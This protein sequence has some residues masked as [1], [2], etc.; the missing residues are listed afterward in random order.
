MKIDIISPSKTLFSGDAELVQL[1]GTL[2]SFEILNDHAPIVS[3]LK[4]GQVKVITDD[5]QT[6]F[7]DV[8]GGVTEVLQNKIIILVKT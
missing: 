2:G 1:P 8:K 4:E 6:L 3:S 7:F 5:K